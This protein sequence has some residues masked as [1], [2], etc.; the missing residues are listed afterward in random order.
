LGAALPFDSIALSAGSLGSG[1]PLP[2]FFG[3]VDLFFFDGGLEL[4]AVTAFFTD[5]DSGVGVRGRF[6]APLVEVRPMGWM[7]IPLFFHW[8]RMVRAMSDS[9]SR[10]HEDFSLRGHEHISHTQASAHG[11]CF[12]PY[13]A[14]LFMASIKLSLSILFG[15]GVNE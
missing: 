9:L 1:L 5:S 2:F 15:K 11:I 10:I 6:W 3:V 13:E 7:R 8:I 4:H 14:D 12:M